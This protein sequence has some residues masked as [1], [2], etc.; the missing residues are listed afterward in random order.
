MCSGYNLACAGAV[1]HAFLLA[2]VN[3]PVAMGDLN[4]CMQVASGIGELTLSEMALHGRP[5]SLNLAFGPGL[6]A[7]IAAVSLRCQ[8]IACRP[9]GELCMN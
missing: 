3:S 9:F 8:F 6:R 1:D 5:L 7:I 4:S 2:F